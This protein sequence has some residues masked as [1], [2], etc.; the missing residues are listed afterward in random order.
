MKYF[1]N[2]PIVLVFCA[3]IRILSMFVYKYNYKHTKFKISEYAADNHF[4]IETLRD[5]SDV[6]QLDC[7]M[8]SDDI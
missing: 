4:K 3:S 5:V 8:A 2:K 6:I 1:F 7:R